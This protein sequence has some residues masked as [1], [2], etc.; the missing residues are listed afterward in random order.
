MLSPVYEVKTNR[1][2][3]AFSMDV[4]VD[5]DNELVIIM[6]NYSP[7]QTVMTWLSAEQL[8]DFITTLQYLREFEIVSRD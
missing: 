3:S 5:G 7:V 8:D 1:R 6:R 4:Y 2:D